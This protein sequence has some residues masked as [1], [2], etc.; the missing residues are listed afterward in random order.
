MEQ[1]TVTFVVLLSANA[2]MRE[3]N[4]QNPVVFTA[5]DQQR[6][7]SLVK[8]TISLLGLICEYAL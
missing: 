4:A 8:P 2:D 3:T 7:P 5:S 6:T 1:K